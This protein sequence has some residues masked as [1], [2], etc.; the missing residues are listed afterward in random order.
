MLTCSFVFE[1]YL[2]V[3]LRLHFNF[4]SLFRFLLSLQPP[5]SAI[6]VHQLG[7]ASLPNC[8][9]DEDHD[10][11]LPSPTWKAAWLDGRRPVAL[12]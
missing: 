6:R 3:L 5:I 2:L 7:P 4:F 11:V 12:P 9:A 10:S 1:A 8:D